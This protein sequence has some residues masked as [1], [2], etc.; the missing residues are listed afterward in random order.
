M[1]KYLELDSSSLLLRDM[2]CEYCVSSVLL[3]FV[4]LFT[5][6]ICNQLLFKLLEGHVMRELKEKR[7]EVMMSDELFDNGRRVQGQD[8]DPFTVYIASASLSRFQ[9][10]HLLLR[11]PSGSFLFR[12]PHQ[13]SEYLVLSYH[14][15]NKVTH[16]LFSKNESEYALD[17]HT[18]HSLQ[19]ILE[20][21]HELLYGIR[22]DGHNQV[23]AIDTM[24]WFTNKRVKESKSRC[25]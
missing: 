17:G 13:Y 7:V 21:R 11:S 8:H 12:N 2:L 19:A 3:P 4:S 24:P 10:E 6:E 25:M 23:I 1:Y 9:C 16:L 5:P 18:Y 22:L 14:L 20:Q 15:H